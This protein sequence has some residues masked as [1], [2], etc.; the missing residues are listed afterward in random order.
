MRLLMET[1]NETSYGDFNDTFLWRLLMR[2][3]MET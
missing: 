2:L 3:I 1:F